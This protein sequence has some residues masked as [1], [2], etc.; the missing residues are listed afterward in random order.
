MT[1]EDKK[2]DKD[3]QPQTQDEPKAVELDAKAFGKSV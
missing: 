3:S 1:E 2:N